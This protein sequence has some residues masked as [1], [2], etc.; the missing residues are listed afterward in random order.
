MAS[1]QELIAAAEY[2]KPKNGLMELL[3]TGIGGYKEGLGIHN[4]RL[5][6]A[7][8]L[9]EQQQYQM[10]LDYMKKTAAE[11]AAKNTQQAFD[12]TGVKPDIAMPAQ[13]LEKVVTSTDYKGHV[14]KTRTYEDQTPKVLDAPSGYKFKADGSLEAI[15]GGPADKVNTGTPAAPAGYRYKPDGTLEV[16]PGGP[17]AK[18]TAKESQDQSN[19]RIFGTRAKEAHMQI[20]N[21][22][23]GVDQA[24][25][26]TDKYDPTSIGTA[27]QDNIPRVIGGN[28]IRSDKGQEYR[29]AKINFMTAVL[30]KES[31]ATIQ[32]S[33]FKTAN[34]QY[35]PIEGDSPGVIAK[36]KQNRET[37]IRELLANRV[38]GNG[39]AGSTDVPVVGGT[40]QGQK[41]KAV[42]RIN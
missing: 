20:E 7:K 9:L 11:E 5:D 31:G 33:E 24:G 38:I 25:K 2:Q 15:P 14:T 41:I 37:V 34:E 4:A 32:A 8:K 1:V 13:K 16:I 21:L 3:D 17:A 12:S 35:F 23:A 19:S 30:R 10:E 27:L 22:L 39:G 29:Q 42:K 40:F 26:P 6:I 36:K 28:F 18:E